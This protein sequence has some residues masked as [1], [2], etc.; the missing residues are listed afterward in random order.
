MGLSPM[1]STA[2]RDR[3]WAIARAVMDE[4]DVDALVVF[5][6]H[7]L[8]GPA[9]FAPD[10]YFTNDRPGAIVV[11]ARDA[12]PVSLVWGPGHVLDHME[13][14]RRAEASWLEPVNIRV[15]KHDH[16]LVA[17]LTERGLGRASIGVIGLEPYPPFHFNPI[18]PY[19][20][21]STVLRQLPFMVVKP[22][23]L[24]F[25]LRT[26]A[27][28]AE[29][30]AAVE[31][32]A[33][34]AHA[35]TLAMLDTAKPGKSEAEVYAAAMAAGHVRGIASPV[36]MLASGPEFVSWG[37]PAWGYRP[38]PPRTLDPGDVLLAELTC[39]YGMRDVQA[40]VA[41]A[42][43]E[44]HPDFDRAADAAR[45]AYAAGLAALR[46][47]GIFGDVCAAVS[48][49]VTAAGGSVLHQLVH[50]LN[51]YGAVSGF[52]RDV[53]ALPGA[54]E[55]GHIAEVTTAGHDLPLVPGMTFS[56]EPNCTLGRH[57]IQLGSTVVVGAEAPTELTPLTTRLLRV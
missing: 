23:W 25:L 1:Y 44:V 35:M 21:W 7:E 32:A 38:Q 42:L 29:E 20:L 3:R 18:M 4:E 54:A 37:P 28:S 31:Y 47:G 45:A 9:P 6:E 41:I 33:M 11:I 40:Q 51:P 24:S 55:Y 14:C 48:G 46:P 50:G 19:L 16:G 2:E 30:I 27:L 57:Q 34:V 13:A 26:M 12:A 53:R 15:A 49:P 17:L 43:G 52:G 10:T 56:L 22:V 36:L 8:A 39:S 5:G